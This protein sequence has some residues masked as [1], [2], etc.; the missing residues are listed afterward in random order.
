LD[1]PDF[2]GSESDGDERVHLFGEGDERLSLKD[3]EI[4][5]VV[6]RGEV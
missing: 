6:D 3:Y 1:R 5:S 2:R 4:R